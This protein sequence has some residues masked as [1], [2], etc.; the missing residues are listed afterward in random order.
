VSKS[1][2]FVLKNGTNRPIALRFRY[3]VCAMQYSLL[4]TLSLLLAAPAA[5]AQTPPIQV[6]ANHRFLVTEDGKPFF[7]LADTAW[8]LFHRLDRQQAVEYLTVRAA[9]KFNVIQAVA[10]AEL[11]GITEP[12]AY[13]KLPFI[14]FD[15][16]RPAVTDGANPLDPKQ[17]DYWDHVDFIVAQANARGLYIALLPTWGSW[18]NSGGKDHSYLTPQ[19]AGIYGEFL[20]KRYGKKGVIWIL[21][22]DR[23]PA[24]FED[25]WR[26]LAKGISIGISG[27][28]DYSAVLM[29]F[30]PRGGATSSTWFHNDPW[31]DFNMNQNGHGIPGKSAPW[32][33]LSGDYNLT[34][35]KPVLDGEPLYED[36]P[37][38]FRAKEFGYS[39]DAHVR[40]YAYS[41][42]FSG[43]CGHTY[44]NHAVWQM[45]APDRKPVNGPL[46]DW[47]AAIHRPGA[48]QMQYL[49]GLLLS[50]PYLSRVPD[51]SIVV[52][53]LDGADRIS[54]TRGDGYLMVYTAQGRKFTVRLGKLSGEQVKGWWYNPRSGA[55]QALEVF[56]NKGER[57]F[58]P[59]SEGFGGD[60]VLVLDDASKN[61]PAPGGALGF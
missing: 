12:N 49:K 9:Q 37:L 32:E 54:A 27:K 5:A 23:S 46:M 44:G 45:S 24:G 15:P 25:T 30:H 17:Y 41:D 16:T 31:L 59:P 7:Y 56:D 39:F 10:L 53:A 47:R 57:E 35:V 14:D 38:G 20:G 48:S 29:S 55:A 13:G 58:T 36:H 11:Q 40:Q 42:T 61:F 43:A 8:E 60:W 22:G 26:A 50:R 2:I 21:G 28:E 19:N 4:W 18:V 33:R 51:Q 3:D 1:C 52:D 34:P 6:S